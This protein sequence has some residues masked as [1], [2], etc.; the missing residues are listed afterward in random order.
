M[1]KRNERGQIQKGEILNPNGRT[2]GTKNFETDFNE[3]VDEL[4]KEE[5][6]TRSEARKMLLKV[7]FRRAN[8]GNFSFYKDIHDRIYGQATEKKEL[9]G[10]LKIEGNKIAFAEYDS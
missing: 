2:E 9:N 10:T 5:K 6:M 8:K 4:A 7:A 1:V 3:A